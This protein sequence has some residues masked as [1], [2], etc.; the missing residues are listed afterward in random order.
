MQVGLTD[1]EISY[2]R[3]YSYKK[4]L[5]FL[6]FLEVNT[7][8]CISIGLCKTPDRFTRI[9]QFSDV[10]LLQRETETSVTKF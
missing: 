4:V 8:H 10:E 5:N 7:N 9:I 6:I 2:L 1:H 3:F